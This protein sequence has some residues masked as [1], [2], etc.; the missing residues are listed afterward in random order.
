M[1]D[2][3]LPLCVYLCVH[4]VNSFADL[5]GV[6]ELRQEVGQQREELLREMNLLKTELTSMLYLCMNVLVYVQT[7]INVYVCAIGILSI[8]TVGTLPSLLHYQ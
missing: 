2:S 8:L 7:Y 6:G 5:G 3:Q 1:T 4:C